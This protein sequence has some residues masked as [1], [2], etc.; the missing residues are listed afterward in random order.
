MEIIKDISAIIGLL[1]SLISLI[2]VCTKKGREL[3]RRWFTIQTRELSEQNE[4]QNKA[5]EQIKDAVD[6]ISIQID[7]LTVNI[8]A[9]EE[10]AKQQCRNTLK[11]IYYKY[12]A[13]ETIP[14]YERKT[15]DKTYEIYHD[16]L[17]GNS[18]ANLLYD[19]ICKWKIDTVSF[20]D[21]EE[22]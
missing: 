17:H 19:E 2:T 13:K 9:L 21:L 6:E 18:Y 10:E 3:I 16:K 20:Q 15:A 14:L 7:G 12:H 22:D 8:N 1:L 4:R 5:I 11:T